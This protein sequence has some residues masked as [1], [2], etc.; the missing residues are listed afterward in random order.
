MSPELKYLLFSVVLTFVQVLIA[1]MAEC[2]V[3][4]MGSQTMTSR[5]E[6]SCGILK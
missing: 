3:A 2:A 6:M 5:S 4:S 1:A